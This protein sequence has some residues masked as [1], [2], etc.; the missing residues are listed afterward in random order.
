MKDNQAS[1]PKQWE[2]RKTL[3]DCDGRY[4][5]EKQLTLFTFSAF[6]QGDITPMPLCIII[7]IG[8]MR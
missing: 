8:G 6:A 7:F 5:R 2:Q 1:V 3:W 4:K